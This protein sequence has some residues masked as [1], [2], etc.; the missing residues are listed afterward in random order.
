MLYEPVIYSNANIALF[1]CVLS[2][3]GYICYIVCTVYRAIEC[4]GLIWLRKYIRNSACKPADKV[5]RCVHSTRHANASAKRI[6]AVLCSHI[7]TQSAARIPPPKTRSRASAKVRRSSYPLPIYLSTTQ[8]D[9]L[10]APKLRRKQS[11]SRVS[12]RN[13]CRIDSEARA[14]EGGHPE[15]R[16][17]V[18]TMRDRQRA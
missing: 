5:L 16:I 6:R 13:L 14:S 2:I 9:S 1:V 17:S 15:R 4:L 18:G 11:K 3:P 10:R 12:R 7:L 8:R